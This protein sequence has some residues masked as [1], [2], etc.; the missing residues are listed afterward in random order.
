LL[1][2][3]SAIGVIGLMFMPS[4]VSAG[5][6]GSETTAGYSLAGG[7]IM[8]IGCAAVRALTMDEDIEEEG[9]DRRGWY[10][11]AG[12]TYARQSFED[13]VGESFINAFD[14]PN[15]PNLNKRAS[16][17]PAKDEIGVNFTAGFRCHPRMAT[18]IEYERM[19][20]YFE[21]P[22]LRRQAFVNDR[23][24]T[25]VQLATF[26]SK[27]YLLTGR[28]QPFG[29]FGVGFMRTEFKQRNR[30]NGKRFYHEKEAVFTL[31][32]GGGVDFYATEHVVLTVGADYIRGFGAL[33]GA[34]M[35]M[36]SLGMQYRF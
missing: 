3:I 36:Y 19:L 34:T 7:S 2:Q 30:S 29:L 5:T 32:M 9:Y 4:S 25:E 6:V 22:A 20:G 21:G 12:G 26:N 16:F 10:V 1:K 35:M 33:D 14:Q 24:D 17:D 13:E 18:E 15:S 28:V 31:R 23:A 11:G 27:G 8:A